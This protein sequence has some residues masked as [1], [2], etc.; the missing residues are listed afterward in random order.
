MTALQPDPQAPAPPETVPVPTEG[1]LTPGEERL[2]RALGKAIGDGINPRAIVRVCEI[3]PE[4]YIEVRHSGPHHG[5][6]RA[7]MVSLYDRD[8][9]GPETGLQVLGNAVCS[10]YDQFARRRGLALAFHRAAKSLS[11]VVNGTPEER[12]T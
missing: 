1:Q 9:N 7:T 10:P 2:H 3:W 6:H 5:R 8:P 4:C 11:W 12:R